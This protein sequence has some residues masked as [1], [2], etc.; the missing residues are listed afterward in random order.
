[1]N[2]AYHHN[3]QYRGKHFSEIIPHMKQINAREILVNK[4][5]VLSVINQDQ[6]VDVYSGFCLKSQIFSL[7][8]LLVQFNHKKTPQ[9]EFNLIVTRKIDGSYRIEEEVKK[10]LDVEYILE[11]SRVNETQGRISVKY[12][13]GN[14]MHYS[15]WEY[16][17]KAMH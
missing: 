9:K 11:I 2:L 10:S 17:L 14:Y 3:Y 8:S 15:S 6:K 13:R 12:L 7:L 16:F 5:G 4:E 1:M